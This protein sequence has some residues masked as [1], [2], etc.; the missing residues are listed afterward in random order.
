[1]QFSRNRALI[2][3]SGIYAYSRGAYP[4]TC[5]L[6]SSLYSFSLVSLM[7]LGLGIFQLGKHVEQR[8]GIWNF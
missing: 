1:M 6:P 7:A 2:I 4:K 3:I 5:N 8:K